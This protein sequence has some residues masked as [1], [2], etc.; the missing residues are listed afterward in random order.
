MKVMA[1]SNPKDVVRQM[2]LAPG[3][4]VADFGAGSGFYTFAAADSVGTDGK[5]YAID[6][7]SDLA[8]RIAAHARDKKYKNVEVL[9]ADIEHTDKLPLAEGSCDGVIMA[10]LLFMLEERGLAFDHAFRELRKGGILLVVDWSDSFAGMGPQ[11]EQVLPAD[12][13]RKLA[14]TRGFQFER[15]I[16]AGSHHWGMLLRKKGA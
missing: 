5:V 1:F 3:A 6:I 15:D 8:S 10:N 7:I 4:V 9:V 16:H 12:A 14:E 13:A 2:G 11:P